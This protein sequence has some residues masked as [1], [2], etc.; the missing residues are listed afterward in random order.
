MTLRQKLLRGFYPVLMRVSYHHAQ[1]NIVTNT[2][3]EPFC[4][5][6]DI[7]VN[8]LYCRPF[9]L[10]KLYGKKILIV[11][12]ASDCGFTAQLKS[13]EKLYQ[14]EGDKLNVLAV[15]SNDFG[16][17]E[18]LEGEEIAQFCTLNFNISFPI[19]EKG[20]VSKGNN[21]CKL[22]RW[23]T[24]AAENGWNNRSPEWNF[25]KFLLNEEGKLTGYFPS[26]I[27]PF[28]EKLLA[29]IRNH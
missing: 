3:T 21:Q 23:L 13:L 17:Q 10:K 28:D 8:D 29:M 12:T 27:S 18:K 22:F 16:G 14:T 4:S 26:A 24:H 5:F 7:N 20:V 15:P 19:L 2:E 11:N 25:T 1:K 9:D 6:Y